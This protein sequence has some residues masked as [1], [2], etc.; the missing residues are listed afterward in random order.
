MPAGGKIEAE[1]AVGSAG[2][3]R[4]I[5]AEIARHHSGCGRG[6]NAIVGISYVNCP[7]P[8]SRQFQ[9]RSSRRCAKVLG[10]QG[11]VVRGGER[12]ALGVRR[13]D[14]LSESGHLHLNWVKGSESSRI[15]RQVRVRH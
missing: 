15:P 5:R 1:L 8:I 6:P 11:E 12:A 13:S 7:A 2:A 3:R 4:G 10:G 9:R 14:H